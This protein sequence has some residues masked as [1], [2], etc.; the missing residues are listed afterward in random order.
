M[1]FPDYTDEEID[2]MAEVGARRAEEMQREYRRTIMI[3]IGV[4]V[5]LVFVVALAVLLGLWSR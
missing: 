2:A 4:H 1:P 3:A 5:M